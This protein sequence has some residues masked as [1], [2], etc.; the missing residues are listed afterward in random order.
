VAPLPQPL[1]RIV[2]PHK[3]VQNMIKNQIFTVFLLSLFL[4]CIFWGGGVWDGAFHTCEYQLYFKNDNNENLYGI[5]MDVY[6]SPDQ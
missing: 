1:K 5:K 4:D 3:K 6:G 2:M